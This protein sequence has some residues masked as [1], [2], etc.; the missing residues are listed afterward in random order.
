MKSIRV[1]LWLGMMVLV[2]IIILL[3]WLFQIVF[4]EKFYS[5]LE[6]NEITTNA[7]K[8]IKEIET[9][10]DADKINT[11]TQL[12]KQIDDIVYEKQ[13]TVEIIVESYNTVYQGSSANN[14]AIPGSMKEVV[15]KAAENALMGT[16][17]KQEVTPEIRIS[18][19]DYWVTNL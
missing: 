14:N 11:S 15:T 7:N 6:I 9:L 5:V 13:L 3:L 10:E 19:Y 12:I 4:L 8:I 2:G 16:N 18:I 1:K 17:F